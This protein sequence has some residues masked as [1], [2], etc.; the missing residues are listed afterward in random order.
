MD[1]AVLNPAVPSQTVLIESAQPSPRTGRPVGSRSAYFS[2]L[3]KAAEKVAGVKHEILADPLLRL[4]EV[5]QV[6][7]ASYN[8]IRKLIKSGDLRVTRTTRNGHYRCRLSEVRRC[9]AA[10]GVKHE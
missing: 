10:L 8:T 1:R 6:M 3:E 9:V 2:I 5:T 4:S 7:N